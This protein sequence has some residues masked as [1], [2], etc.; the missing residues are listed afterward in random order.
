MV[1]SVLLTMAY[2]VKM[3]DGASLLKKLMM[4]AFLLL[5]KQLLLKLCLPSPREDSLM[6]DRS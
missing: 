6:D 5:L 3:I 4:V 1:D 2:H